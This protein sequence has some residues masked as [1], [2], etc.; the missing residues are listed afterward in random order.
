MDCEGAEMEILENT[1]DRLLRSVSAVSLEYH[2]D[3]YPRER[4]ERSKTRME[5]LGFIMEIRPTSKP[6][7]ILRG[8]R[9][10]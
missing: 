2:L 7:G 4:L 6:L 5:S 1:P 8:I 10:G 9:Q 3:A